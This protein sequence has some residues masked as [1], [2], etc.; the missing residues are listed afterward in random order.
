MARKAMLRLTE[1]NKRR[2][3][4]EM[5]QWCAENVQDIAAYAEQQ[6][7]ELWREAQA[8]SQQLDAEAKAKLPRKN[9]WARR[10]SRAAA[11]RPEETAG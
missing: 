4:N 3:R 2:K 1:L 9:F 6:D 10:A 11:I 7:A 5:L 8:F